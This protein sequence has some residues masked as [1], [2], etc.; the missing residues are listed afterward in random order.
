MSD[1]QKTPLQDT[2]KPLTTKTVFSLAT[3]TGLSVASIYYSQPMLQVM[4]DELQSS[5]SMTGMIPTLTQAGYALGIF[6]L[7]PLGDRYNRRQLILLKTGI[8]M[9]I[10]ALSGISP[11]IY[12]LL[13]LSLMIGIM[14]TVAQD[15]VPASAALAPSGQ[16][17]KIVGTV[18]T[19]LLLGILL[20]R[21]V[22]GLVAE[23]FGWRMLYL[24]AA[25][26]IGLS[27]LLLWRILPRFTPTTGLS[28]PAL[29]RSL[30]RLWQQ[31]P[32]LRR[33]AL[34]Q[35]LLAISFSAFWSTLAVMLYDNY[36]LGSAVAGSFGLAGAAGALIAPLAGMLADKQGPGRVALGGAAIVF[37]SFSA[38]LF[39]PFFSLSGQLLLLVITVICFDLGVQAAL[40]AHQTLV[41]GLEPAARGRLNAVFFTTVFIGMATGSA[42]GS[43]LLDNVSWT[44]VVVLATSTAAISLLMRISSP[45]PR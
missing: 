3:A 16:R 24:L 9:L 19:G 41:Y 15:I 5:V 39:M 20:S 36:Q 18:M 37:L 7:I 1:T 38:M 12:S 2:E 30:F 42:A 43:W 25:G 29:L 40:I 4:G 35:A 17:G 13:L 11:G 44:A 34:S 10:L 8:L 45:A 22:S 21:T 28:Y 26:S 14:A 33:A 32:A 31:Y 6:L 27:G 23:Y